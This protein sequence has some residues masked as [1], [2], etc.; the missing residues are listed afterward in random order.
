MDW[1]AME[2]EKS[3]A[4][5]EERERLLAMSDVEAEGLPVPDRYQ[6]IRYLSELDAAKWLAELRRGAA[7]QADS[8]LGSPLKKRYS[9]G[10][11]VD[12]HGG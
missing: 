5:S 3:K 12:Y 9:K 6:R 11:H 4:I 7:A 1:E 8:P 2:K 10:A